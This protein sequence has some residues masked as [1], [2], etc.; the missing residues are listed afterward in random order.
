MS[1]PTYKQKSIEAMRTLF[2]DFDPIENI[3][4]DTS[5]LA[6]YARGMVNL[7]LTLFPYAGSD[8]DTNVYDVWHY[9][10]FPKPQTP[11]LAE[12]ATTRGWDFDKVIEITLAWRA[13]NQMVTLDEYASTV[14]DSEDGKI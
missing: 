10:V 12:Q 3:L 1:N 11:T 4:T 7:H 13:G 14:A 2:E 5:S 8:W 9:E 6:E